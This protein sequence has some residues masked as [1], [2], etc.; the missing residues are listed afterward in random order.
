M[1]STRAANLLKKSALLNKSNLHDFFQISTSSP[2]NSQDLNAYLA[3]KKR[4]QNSPPGF[5]IVDEDN[6]DL[7]SLA[8]GINAIVSQI[9]SVKDTLNF[10]T[11]MMAKFAAKSDSSDES[12]AALQSSNNFLH[13]SRL[14]D[15]MEIS[16]LADFSAA[17]KS[18]YRDLVLKLF[19]EWKIELEKVEIADV[20]ATSRKDREGREK[21][22][23]IVVFIHEAIKSRV[24]KAKMSSK[25]PQLKN[26]Y[27]N[28]VL[29]HPNRTL[30][31]QARQLMKAGQFAKVG[32]I[33]GKV[34]V[35]KSSSGQKI[36]I[37]NIMEMEGI[38]KLPQEN[39]A[40]SSVLN[41]FPK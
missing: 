36:F 18:E 37:Q 21:S 31:Y 8:M 24:M 16:G 3:E 14:N 38:A 7:K 19:R 30:V 27:F 22:Y 33:N 11:N 2:S 15:R 17:N 12:I 34:Y 39:I 23:L 29:T 13:Q 40:N 20:Y 9:G 10:Q 32:T 41:N 26:I 6:A 35:K 5:S 28:E 1:S 4:R 25:M